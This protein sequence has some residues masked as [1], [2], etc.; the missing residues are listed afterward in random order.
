MKGLFDR[1]QK[2]K[3]T[4]VL[5]QK[6]VL[7]INEL[8][9]AQSAGGLVDGFFDIAGDI[10]GNVLD[11]ATALFRRSVAL[12]LISATVADG[13]NFFILLYNVLLLFK[14]IISM[15]LRVQFLT[16]LY[17]NRKR[18]SGRENI[19]EICYYLLTNIGR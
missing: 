16:F 12:W 17:R 8:T 2:V 6:N 15:K 4:V 19:S 1:H 9:A 11:T 5:M 14:I 7:D 13:N 18:Q 3:G 10:A